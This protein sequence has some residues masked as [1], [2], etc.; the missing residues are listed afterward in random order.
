MGI[1]VSA[2]AI[3]R[4]DDRWG[5]PSAALMAQEELEEPEPPELEESDEDEEEDEEDDDD[6]EDEPPSLEV[7]ES[8]F[9]ACLAS[10]LSAPE[11][12]ERSISRLRLA[13]P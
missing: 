10:C 6:D 7:F 11:D 2:P 5:A 4:D 13:V 3:S 9:S 8:R 12:A 1:S